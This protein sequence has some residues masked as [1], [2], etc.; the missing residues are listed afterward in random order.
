MPEYEIRVQIVERTSGKRTLGTLCKVLNDEETQVL[1]HASRP[2]PDPA[3]NPLTYELWRRAVDRRDA[4]IRYLGLGVASNVLSAFDA[5][6]A[7]DP[8]RRQPAGE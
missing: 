7:F 3:D 6:G 4:L 8:W 1:H 5:G 2:A